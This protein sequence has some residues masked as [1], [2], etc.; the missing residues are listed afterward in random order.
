MFYADERDVLQKLAR[1]LE[2]KRQVVALGG[3]EFSLI[4]YGEF[5]TMYHCLSKSCSVDYIGEVGHR[6]PPF[7]VGRVQRWACRTII[8]IHLP[9]VSASLAPFETVYT[10]SESGMSNFHFRLWT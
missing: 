2:V 7:V 1:K 9:K 8:I 10:T 5:L 6:L 4:I 3:T